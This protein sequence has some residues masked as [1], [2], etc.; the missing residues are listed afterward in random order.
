M[1][2]F[3]L[4]LGFCQQYWLL[5]FLGLRQTEGL[6]LLEPTCRFL[7]LCPCT[8]WQEVTKM[9]ARQNDQIVHHQGYDCH[10]DWTSQCGLKLTAVT[11][12]AYPVG[13][14]ETD[15]F[16]VTCHSFSVFGDTFSELPRI[17]VIKQAW[18]SRGWGA[19]KFL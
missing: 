16:K 13:Y 7:H 12:Q 5:Q 11:M 15:K 18:L 6:L 14:T 1:V 17:A 3:E 19:S 2:W 4:D 8:F 10:D 9:L